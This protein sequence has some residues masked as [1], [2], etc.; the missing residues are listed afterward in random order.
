MPQAAPALRCRRAS[1]D[2]RMA[3]P[4]MNSELKSGRLATQQ[5]HHGNAVI[6]P[7]R[8]QR[9]RR[10]SGQETCRPPPGCDVRLVAG[11]QVR[12]EVEHEHGEQH[13]RAYAGMRARFRNCLPS[14]AAPRSGGHTGQDGVQDAERTRDGVVRS[15]GELLAAERQRRTGASGNAEDTVMYVSSTTMMT[16]LSSRR[17]PSTSCWRYRRQPALARPNDFQRTIRP[18]CRP[19]PTHRSGRRT[20]QATFDRPRRRCT[21]CTRPAR[22][23]RAHDNERERQART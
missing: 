11:K 4:S 1:Q 10:I 16:L 6:V 13:E 18:R 23:E 9:R 14:V 5:A 3:L 17:R 22:D 19:A 2:A 21:D 15:R 8:A 7:G 20:A 12:D